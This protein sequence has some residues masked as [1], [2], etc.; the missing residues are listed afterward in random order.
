MEAYSRQCT[1]NKQGIDAKRRT[2][3]SL[4]NIGITRKEE[5][6]DL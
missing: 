6:M 1:V 3:R 5:D 4:Q 2:T